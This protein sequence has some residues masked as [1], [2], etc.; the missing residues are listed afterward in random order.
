[1]ADC[2]AAGT[3]IEARLSEPP[4]LAVRLA[5]GSSVQP[6]RVADP[7]AKTLIAPWMSMVVSAREPRSCTENPPTPLHRRKAS[8]TRLASLFPKRVRVG[9]WGECV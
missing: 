6:E 7:P 5:E 2:S 8:Q 9:E 3:A 1:M 4:P